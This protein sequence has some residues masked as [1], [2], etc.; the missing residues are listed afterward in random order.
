MSAT[1]ADNW[2]ETAPPR[3]DRQTAQAVVQA[4]WGLEGRLSPLYAERDLNF[5]L[6][7][8]NGHSW[9]LKFSNADAAPANLAL[10]RRVL[11]HLARH[12][13]KLPVP[14]LHPTL[15]GQHYC[16]FQSASQT[17]CV[18][19]LSWLPG[20]RLELAKAGSDAWARR[21]IGSTLAELSLA[22]ADC[23][24]DG[25]PEDLPWDL[26]Q[27]TQLTP[28]ASALEGN[29]VHAL[30][31]A[32]LA[33]HQQRLL[34]ALQQWPTQLIHNDANPGNLLFDVE[35]KTLTGLFDFGDMIEAPLICELAVACAY[36]VTL[37]DNPLEPAWE[38]VAAWQAIRPLAS[39]ELELLPALIRSRI[40]T[41]LLIQ[42]W[43]VHRGLDPNGGLREDYEEAS[44]RLQALAALGND[45][46][47]Q[48]LRARLEAQH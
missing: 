38:L 22:L 4:N 34:P 39:A 24:A 14:R 48:S 20:E 16:Q 31:M 10:Q 6:D 21:A 5:R 26:R 12:A 43:R 13:P 27:L 40:L 44:Q 41:T 25:A 9:L 1:D 47:I 33:D 30:A 15:A 46:A 11:L 8:R 28:L 36:L 19:L 17:H 42:G 18:Q 45:A 2:F 7:D 23:E 3:L 35:R 29:P 32:A 37:G